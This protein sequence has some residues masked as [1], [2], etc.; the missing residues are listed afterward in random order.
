MAPVPAKLRFPAEVRELA[1]PAAGLH[2]QGPDGATQSR[3]LILLRLCPGAC[4]SRVGSPRVVCSVCPARHGPRARAPLQVALTSSS[5][6]GAPPCHCPSRQHLRD[7]QRK[8]SGQE[9]SHHPFLPAR[10]SMMASPMAQTE[11]LTG[12]LGAHTT[13]GSDPQP[14]WTAP[15]PQCPDLARTSHSLLPLS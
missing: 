3:T 2:L 5:L 15:T 4:Q 7:R 11:T 6:P 13:A 10:P 12:T 9:P 14:P 8:T 1:G